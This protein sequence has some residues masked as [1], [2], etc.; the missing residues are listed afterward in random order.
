MSLKWPVYLRAI[1]MYGRTMGNYEPH[2]LGISQKCA[3]YI[4]EK[5]GDL[6]RAING[7]TGRIEFQGTDASE[8]IQNALNN[9]TP[10]RTWKERVVCIGEF[11]IN[12]NIEIPSYTEI[13]IFGKLKFNS[14]AYGLKIVGKSHVSI[15][16]GTLEAEDGRAVYIHNS[17]HVKVA[18]CKFIW[19]NTTDV[20]GIL[21]ISQFHPDTSESNPSKY[22]EILFNDFYSENVNRETLGGGY[23]LYSKIISNRFYTAHDA[24]DLVLFQHSVLSENVIEYAGANGIELEGGLLGSIICN[25]TIKHAGSAGIYLPLK[26]YES[27]VSIIANNVIEKTVDSNGVWVSVTDNSNPVRGLII[28]GN[29]VEDAGDHSGIAV[30]VD[31]VT[32]YNVKIVNNLVEKSKTGLEIAF[33]GTASVSKFFV[34]NNKL[35]GSTYSLSFYKGADAEVSDLFIQHNKLYGTVNSN[36]PLTNYNVKWNHG[37]VTEN[38]GVATFSGDG[39]TTQFK[40][41]HGLVKAPSVVIVT[42][43]SADAKDFSYAEADDTYIYFNFSTAPPSGTDNVKLSWYAEV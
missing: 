43:L 28:A 3:S 35:E 10:N 40:I 33:T 7:R 19:K 32:V 38:S 42:S 34:G 29:Q 9:L 13:V 5:D 17:D 12:S 23:L 20:A 26:T 1:D 27:G 41:E 2:E 4:I 6:V 36:V 24:I 14:L 39:T 21:F 22:I 30:G 11:N 18:H 31:S 37:Y 15:L 16:C 8:V 25:N